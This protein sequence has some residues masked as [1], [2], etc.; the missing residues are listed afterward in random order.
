M[1]RAYPIFVT[2]LT[3]LAPHNYTPPA[4]AMYSLGLQRELVP[5]VIWVLQ[6]VGNAGWH[7]WDNRQINNIPSTIGNVTIPEPGGT[8]ASVPV[9][10]LA[11]DPGNHSPFG[12]D[13]L[14]KPGFQSFPAE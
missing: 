4:V 2:S 12:D 3:T 5:S 6:Y 11:G 10:C 14:C 1:H 8:S 9:T 7:Q 13:T